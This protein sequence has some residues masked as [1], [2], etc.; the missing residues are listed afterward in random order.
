LAKYFVAKNNV[1]TL[2]H[3]SL[4]LAPA[5]FYLFSRLKLALNGGA[6]VMPLTS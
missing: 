4:D 6:F 1:T 2:V 5:D 3:P